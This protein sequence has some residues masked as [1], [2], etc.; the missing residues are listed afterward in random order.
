MVTLLQL[1][2]RQTKWNWTVSLG[3]HEA[4]ITSQNNPTSYFHSISRRNMFKKIKIQASGRTNLR[5]KTIIII[6]GTPTKL[7]KRL[8]EIK[9]KQQMHSVR[10]KS[11]T[12]KCVIIHTCSCKAKIINTLSCLWVRICVWFCCLGFFGVYRKLSDYHY[13]GFSTR[14]ST[15][16]ALFTSMFLPLVMRLLQWILK[17]FG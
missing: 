14:P 4:P 16:T 12:F 8:W 1:S 11:L 7:C 10:I 3:G 13:V 9:L 5:I 15:H 6:W 2:N 17:L